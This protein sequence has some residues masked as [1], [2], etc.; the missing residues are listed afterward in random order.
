MSFF[1]FLK[2]AFEG[3]GRA[4]LSSIVS[5]FTI[6]I[7]LFLLGIFVLITLN[8]SR[9]IDDFREK[10]EIEVFLDKSLDSESI[11]LTEGAILSIQ[12]VQSLAF[13]SREMAMDILSKEIGMDNL[14][15]ALG[16]NP[17]PPSFKINLKKEFRTYAQITQIAEKLALIRGVDDVVYSRD[18]LKLVDERVKTI[19]WIDLIL[20]VIIAFSA[21]LLVSNTIR[22]TIY[23]KRDIVK[24]MKLVG[25]SNGF[26]RRPFL[27]EGIIQGLIGGGLAVGLL[28]A[29]TE[30]VR[31]Y[32]I[33][34]I[35]FSPYYLYSLIVFGALLGLFG[36]LISIR[37]FLKERISD[38]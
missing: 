31:R 13:I 30:A 4:T 17:L 8:L 23:A 12:G 26:I 25:A 27:I 7:S 11:Q 2:E 20:G 35:E 5:I 15:E 34:E 32:L 1:Y 16:D 14:A 33:S 21:V 29:S 6:C 19:T 36:S 24:T 9:L 37:F 22:L 10:V 28:H 38:M 18:L 3:F